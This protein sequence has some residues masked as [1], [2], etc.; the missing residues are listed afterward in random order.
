[1]HS[2]LGEMSDTSCACLFQLLKVLS[3]RTDVTEPCRKGFKASRELAPMKALVEFVTRTSPEPA[4][5]PQLYFL[6]D[7]GVKH[8]RGD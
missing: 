6:E 8:P 1:M 7:A 2:T 5:V 3:I 4:D